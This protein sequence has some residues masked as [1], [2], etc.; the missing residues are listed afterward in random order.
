V[1]AVIDASALVAFCL[2][3]QGLDKEKLKEHLRNGVISIELI[4]AE[5][6]NAILV[7]KRRATIDEKDA[8]LALAGMLELSR[9]NVKMIPQDDGL[10]SD[11]FGSSESNSLAIYDLLYLSLAKKM[12]GMLLSKDESQI[13]LA[14]KLGIMVE[15]I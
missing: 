1:T 9:N 12:G 10:I 11:A 7:A 13:R 15:N 14:R 4:K 5:S 2:N 3:E 6:A 8:K